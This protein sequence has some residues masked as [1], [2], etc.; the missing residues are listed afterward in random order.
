MEN[1]I[2]KALGENG[3]NGLTIAELSKELKQSRFI[4]RNA[5]Y[6]L[7]ALNAV[8][9][10]KASVAKIYFLKEGDRQPILKSE[11]SINKAT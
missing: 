11:V 8:Y 3:K 5:L 10:R 9:F 7:E 6:R 4:V 1:K 2:I